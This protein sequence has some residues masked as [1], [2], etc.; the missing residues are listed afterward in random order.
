MANILVIDDDIAICKLIET[1]LKRDG[2]FVITKNSATEVTVNDCKHTDLIL[3]DIMMPQLDGITFCREYRNMIDCPILFLT[4][5]TMEHDVIDGLS[6]GG[7]DYIKKPFSVSELRA[8]VN[9][10]IRREHRDRHQSFILND[11]VFDL[12]EKTLT[13]KNKL[14]CLTKS[15]YEICE[16]LA[17][18]KGQI[19]SLETILEKIFGFHSESDISSIRVHIKN[20]RSKFSEIMDCPIETVWG[21]GYKWK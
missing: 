20:I 17:R 21:V 16:L 4:A 6:V 14:I 12:S 8:R 7:D 11:C 5:K 3:L 1:A 15:E 13:I 19:F 18:N 2:H 10:H 9:A